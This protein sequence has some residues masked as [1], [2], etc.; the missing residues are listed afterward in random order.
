VARTSRLPSERRAANYTGW[1]NAADGV[2]RTIDYYETTER[3]VGGR[4]DTQESFRRFVIPGM[5]HCGGGD[6][7]FAVDY[8][9]YLEAWVERGEAPDV[10]MSSHVQTK[11]PADVNFPLDPPKI[12]FTRPVYPYPITATYLGQ[13]EPRDAASFGPAERHSEPQH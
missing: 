13:G 5:D 9:R 6:G 11:S 1:A 10:L 2:L 3:V 4:R 8:L 12:E 7:A